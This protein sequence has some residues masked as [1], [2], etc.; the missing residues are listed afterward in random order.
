MKLEVGKRE[1]D[2]CR[3]GGEVTGTTPFALVC[4]S[5]RDA[6]FAS[7]T[8][9]VVVSRL[10]GYRSWAPALSMYALTVSLAKLQ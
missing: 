8:V 10:D 9:L 5:Q 7:Q 2:G 6:K 1:T 4:A 3:A